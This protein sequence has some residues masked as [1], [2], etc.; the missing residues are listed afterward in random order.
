MDKPANGYEIVFGIS[1]SVLNS[2]L[3]SSKGHRRRPPSE[4]QYCNAMNN[5]PL[6]LN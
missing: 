2:D 4:Q 3:L 5:N 6:K 1:C